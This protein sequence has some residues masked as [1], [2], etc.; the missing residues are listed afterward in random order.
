MVR[1]FDASRPVVRGAC[2][3][4]HGQDSR[5]RPKVSLPERESLGTLAD[6]LTSG[7]KIC[8]AHTLA[9]MIHIGLVDDDLSVR[10]SV[11]R[12]LRTHG[13]ACSTYDSGEAALAD[14]GFL[15]MDCHVVDVQLGGI[16]GVELCARIKA[17]GPPI[18]HVFITALVHDN[19]SELDEQ[20]QSDI[21][22]TK[23][24]EEHQLID[25]IH[26]VLSGR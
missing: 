20:L 26:R 5:S 18:P 22:L 24:F 17:L 8:D 14:P 6:V 4:A 13:Y 15:Q 10:R 23:P 19:R 9:N 1:V 21:L 12:L 3:P 11:G 2:S 16:N 25:S 7:R